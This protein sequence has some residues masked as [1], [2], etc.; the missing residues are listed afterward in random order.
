M[1]TDSNTK[2]VFCLFKNHRESITI[3]ASLLS[4]CLGIFIVGSS[5]LGQKNLKYI[6]S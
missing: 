5:Q 3:K 4:V 2:S 6:C 1:E